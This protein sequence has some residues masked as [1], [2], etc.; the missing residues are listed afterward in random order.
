MAKPVN[1]ERDIRKPSREEKQPTTGEDVGYTLNGITII[2]DT[3]GKD[4]DSKICASKEPVESPKST[5]LGT[6]VVSI[7]A[8]NNVEK[9]SER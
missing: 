4:I 9:D 8:E 6:T 2:C 7:K 3:R 5:D 1:K